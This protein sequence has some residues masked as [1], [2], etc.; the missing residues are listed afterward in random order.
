MKPGLNIP[1]LLEIEKPSHSEQRQE[2][3][4]VAA[5]TV[6]SEEN[7]GSEPDRGAACLWDQPEEIDADT[8]LW[9]L[10]QPSA[11]IS[12]ALFMDRIEFRLTCYFIPPIFFFLFYMLLIF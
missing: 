7:A 9:P 5:S 3:R 1:L 4:A 2:S 6:S 11:S 12:A 8:H 10:G